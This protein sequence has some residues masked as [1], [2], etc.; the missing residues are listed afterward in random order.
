MN[1]V[2]IYGTLQNKHFDFRFWKS[3]P[4][5]LEKFNPSRSQLSKN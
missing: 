5:R 1:G 2:K 3:D 4:Y